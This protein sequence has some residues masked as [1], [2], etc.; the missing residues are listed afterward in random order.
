MGIG[1]LFAF[2]CLEYV[3]EDNRKVV[4]ADIVEFMAT[5]GHIWEFSTVAT[6]VVCLQPLEE[7]LQKLLLCKQ[8]FMGVVSDFCKGYSAHN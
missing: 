2:C 8:I 7:K 1:Q 3:G 6:R 5:Q 4:H